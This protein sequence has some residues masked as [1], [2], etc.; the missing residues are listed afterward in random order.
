V[1]SVLRNV[2][3]AGLTFVL[4]IVVAATARAAGTFFVGTCVSPSFATIQA[5]VNAASA[6]ST[7]NVCPGT[8]PEQVTIDKRL[9]LQGITVGTA[10]QAVVASP[11]GGVVA[12]TISLATGNPLAVANLGA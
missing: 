7:V 10:N 11:A 9:T 6:G 4:A 5:G 2:I 8:Y 12:S 3:L 1:K